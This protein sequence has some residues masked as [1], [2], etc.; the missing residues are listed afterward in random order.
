MDQDEV[1]ATALLPSHPEQ[2]L[3][4]PVTVGPSKGEIEP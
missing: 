2:R 4:T 1:P 3:A